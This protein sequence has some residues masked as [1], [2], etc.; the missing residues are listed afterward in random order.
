[1][2]AEYDHENLIHVSSLW[3]LKTKKVK[4]EETPIGI[5]MSCDQIINEIHNLN[6]FL[7]VEEII[8]IVEKLKKEGWLLC[9]GQ[10]TEKDSIFEGRPTLNLLNKSVKDDRLIWKEK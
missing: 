6:S 8:V 9:N 7:S 1:M 3:F 5:T 4:E 10:P 2:K